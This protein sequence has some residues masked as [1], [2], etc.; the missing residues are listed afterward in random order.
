MKTNLILAACLA[1]FATAGSIAQTPTTGTPNHPKLTTEQ[2]QSRKTE[3]LTKLAQM[4]P[5]ERQSFKKARYQ[6]RQAKLHAMSPDK[7][8][9][10]LARRQ[11]RKAIKQGQG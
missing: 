10:A 5:A 8:A 6:Q 1:L 11:I 7:R 9:K 2:R 4:T 3:R